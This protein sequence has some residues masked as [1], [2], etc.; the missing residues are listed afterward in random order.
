M[1]I[2]LSANAKINLAIT[3]GDKLQNGYHNVDMIMQSVS[4]CDFLE[5]ETTNNKHDFI[6]ECDDKSLSDNDN[7]LNKAIEEFD[8]ICPFDFGLKITLQKNIPV[9]AG[10]AGGSADAGA[11]LI[12]LNKLSDHPLEPEELEE[13]A[14]K[15]GADVPF[16]LKGGTMRVGGIGE[17]LWDIADIPNCHIILIKNA[18]KLSTGYM[19][20][21]LDA[22]QNRKKADIDKLE[23]AINGGDLSEISK[24]VSNDFRLVWDERTEEVIKD[25]KSLGALCSEIT[26]SGPTV[27][28]IFDDG[29][30]AV[31]AY[32]KLKAKYDEIYITTPARRAVEILK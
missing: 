4:L 3:V 31:S 10:M 26:G 27:F 6:F 2:K 32:R 1:K 24:F 22:E 13:V 21:K 5:V 28:G 18:D 19:Y 15:I 29:K 8:K 20:N 11:M 16:M 25:M 9:A 12:A 14:L 17:K 30:V 23:N 7:I